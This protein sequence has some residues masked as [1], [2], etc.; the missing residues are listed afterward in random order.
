[1]LHEPPAYVRADGRVCAQPDTWNQFWEMLPGRRR[2][3]GG[4]EP[5]LPLILGAW[6]GTPALHKWLRMEEHIRFADAHGVLP[7]V[8]AFLRGLSEGEWAHLGDF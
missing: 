3:G 8:D 4:W 6:R 7:G 1:M 2:S 5:P